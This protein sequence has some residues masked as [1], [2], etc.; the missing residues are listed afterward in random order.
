MSATIWTIR[1]AAIGAM[2]TLFVIVTRYALSMSVETLSDVGDVMSSLVA[3]VMA[4]AIPAQ[5]AWQTRCMVAGMSLRNF[6]RTAKAVGAVHDLATKAECALVTCGEHERYFRSVFN[7]SQIDFAIERV[8]S[9][10]LSLL[11]NAACK[12]AVDNARH[13]LHLFFSALQD[14][15]S[16]FNDGRRISQTSVQVL[17]LAYVACAREAQAVQQEWLHLSQ[18]NR[19]ARANP[20][21]H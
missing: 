9:I 4:L 3:V 18:I 15:S 1:D 7:Q 20:L 14:V 8:D 12:A 13:H 16:D 6:Q 21:E 11:P 17:H 2:A 5:L 10:D 19:V